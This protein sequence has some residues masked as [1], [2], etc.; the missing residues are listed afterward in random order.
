VQFVGDREEALHLTQ[1]HAAPPVTA[2]QR[3][4][5]N[6]GT[7]RGGLVRRLRIVVSR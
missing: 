7:G 5:V 2:R 4:E 1:V 3:H 6:P